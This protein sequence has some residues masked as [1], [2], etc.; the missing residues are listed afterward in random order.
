M[1]GQWVRCHW[2]SHVGEGYPH[3]L[4]SQLA[5]PVLKLFVLEDSLLSRHYHTTER[6]RQK[7]TP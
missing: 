2:G 4:G 7:K 3:T 1:W 5:V 6:N